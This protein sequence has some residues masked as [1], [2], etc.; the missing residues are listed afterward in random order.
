MKFIRGAILALLLLPALVWAGLTNAQL[1]TLK[2]AIAADSN[3][4]QHPNNGDGNAEI[5]AKLN[6]LATPDKFIWR[7]SITRSQIY[8]STS[9][10]ATTWSW[11]TYKAQSVTEQ[12]A[13]TQMF[14][15]D[16]VDP[17]LDNLRAGVAAIF[18]GS[19]QQNAQRDHVYAVAKRKATRAEALFA[20]GTGSQA[21]PAKLGVGTLG[22]YIE[23]LLS[24]DEIERA[25]NFPG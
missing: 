11:S 7:S 8:H 20:V 9:A 25:R 15:G 18:T 12:N 13:W 2:A 21:V 3:L 14:M 1:S 19:A 16:S 10:E 5:A 22:E 23:G 6:V 4:N 24:T 17:S